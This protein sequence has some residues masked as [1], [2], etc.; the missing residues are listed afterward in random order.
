MHGCMRC[1]SAGVQNRDFVD[2][3]RIVRQVVAIPGHAGNFFDQFDTVSITLSEYRVVPIQARIRNLSD[4]KL[5]AVG[6]GP[7]VGVRKATR[8]GECKVWKGV[9]IELVSGDEGYIL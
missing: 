5:R 7:G 1:C 4:E 9:V 6:V 3:W 2:L 8:T